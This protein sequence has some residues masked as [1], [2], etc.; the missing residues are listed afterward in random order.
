[1]LKAVT[2]NQDNRP[3]YKVNLSVKNQVQLNIWYE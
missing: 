3:S 1:M 2:Y